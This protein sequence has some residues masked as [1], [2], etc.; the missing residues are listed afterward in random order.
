MTKTKELRGHTSRILHLATSPDGSMVCSA[1]ADETLRF[2]N[3]FAPESNKR[4]NGDVCDFALAA[5]DGALN[6]ASKNLKIR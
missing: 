4:K 2:W 6:R 1:A 3:V 5:K